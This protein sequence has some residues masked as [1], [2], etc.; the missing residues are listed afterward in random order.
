MMC[1]IAEVKY[2]W[3]AKHLGSTNG[4]AVRKDRSGGGKGKQKPYP[5]AGARVKE[6]PRKVYP[7]PTHAPVT[8]ALHPS[9]VAK[10]AQSKQ[11]AMPGTGVKTTFSQD[12][13]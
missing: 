13:E 8:E 7:P 6:Q 10:A 4:E 11:L 5:N 9:W 12:D 3:A 2:G 1:R